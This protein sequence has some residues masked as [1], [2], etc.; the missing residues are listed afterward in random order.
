[1]DNNLII[2]VASYDDVEV[3]KA[4]AD[5]LDELIRQDILN[6]AAVA[7]I[8][9]DENGKLHHH[10]DTNAG[11]AL[12]AVGALGGVIIGA[13]FPP[14]GLAILGGMLT[15]GVTLGV[16]G[17]AIGHF[18]GGVSRKDLNALGDMLADGEAAVVV[19]VN[20][21]GADKADAALAHAA[22]KAQHLLDK[23]DVEAAFAE[24]DKGAEKAEE[25]L[26]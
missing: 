17:A 9:K 10:Q 14:A 2:L 6:D 4:D 11:K 7:L 13:L 1:M 23:G 22:R 3:A 12:G 16:V 19:V 8:H 21:E 15:G 25:A 20:D 26:S 18:A 24:L 5:A